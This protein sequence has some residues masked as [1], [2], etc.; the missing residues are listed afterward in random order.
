MIV[1][2]FIVSDTKG[3]SCLYEIDADDIVM[4]RNTCGSFTLL[5]KNASVNSKN[6]LTYNQHRNIITI[7][8]IGEYSS[9]DVSLT[10][11]SLSLIN[12]TNANTVLL[13]YSTN[14]NKI[15]IA[16]FTLNMNTLTLTYVNTVLNI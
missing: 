11:S 1:R 9:T 10:I 8:N 6:I 2:T 15:N 5:L 14:T 7:I 3:V 13:T 16:I 12:N 4:K